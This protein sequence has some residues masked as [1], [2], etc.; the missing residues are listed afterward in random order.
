MDFANIFSKRF[1]VVLLEHTEIKTYTINLEDSKH[2]PYKT[3]YSL[4]PIELETLKT[5]IKTN[6]ANDFIYPSKSPTDALIL[7][8]K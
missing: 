4:R 1:T 2:L 3:I 8:N 7:F 6:L 5:Y